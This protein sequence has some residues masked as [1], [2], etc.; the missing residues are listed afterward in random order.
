MYKER[1]EEI[2]VLEHEKLLKQL[3]KEINEEEAERKIKHLKM[4]EE[5]EKVLDGRK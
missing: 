2:K 1:G 3:E 4:Q 5:L